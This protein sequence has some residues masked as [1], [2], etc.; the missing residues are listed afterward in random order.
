MSTTISYIEESFQVKSST[1]AAGAHAKQCVGV[2]FI[3]G[4]QTDLTS[5][6]AKAT[7]IATQVLDNAKM[8]YCVH[9]ATHG[10]LAD[11]KECRQ[12]LRGVATEP[13]RL[14]RDQIVQALNTGGMQRFVVIAHSQGVIHTVNALRLIKTDQKTANLIDQIAVLAIAPPV[15]IRSQDGLC[16][17]V[18]HIVG[19]KDPI[20]RLDSKG[21]QIALRERT[22]TKVQGAGHRLL[23][24]N[25]LQPMQ[26]AFRA[27]RAQDEPALKGVV[28]VKP[29]GRP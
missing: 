23:D 21:M 8:S 13:A 9:N 2:G 6:Q 29:S 20:P 15:F 7:Y 10:L 25:Y 22:V 3:N 11:L 27:L 5:A 26:E 16:G 24:T 17:R 28:G 4:I 18:Q 1:Y 19:S 12:G 14:L